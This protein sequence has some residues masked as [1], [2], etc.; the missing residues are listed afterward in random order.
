MTSFG[1]ASGPNQFGAFLRKAPFMFNLNPPQIFDEDKTNIPV[2]GI[3]TTASDYVV[4]SSLKV[5]HLLWDLK[6]PDLDKIIRTD[7]SLLLVSVDELEARIN[8]LLNI[9]SGPA[10]STIAESLTNSSSAP[11]NYYDTTIGGDSSTTDDSVEGEFV[12]KGENVVGDRIRKEFGDV[13]LDTVSSKEELS[14]ILYTHKQLV[15]VVLNYPKVLSVD[16][17]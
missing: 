6:I 5:L 15:A 11:H 10:V 9:L 1:I 3:S 17:R 4:Y 2:T 14:N 16:H 12:E 7:P 8:F 13:K